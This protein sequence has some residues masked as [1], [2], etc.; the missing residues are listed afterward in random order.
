M[1][2]VAAVARIPG[3]PLV[4]EEIELD[5]PRDDEVLVEVAACGVCHTDAKA[6]HGY[7]EVRLP[8]VLGH[9]GAVTVLEVG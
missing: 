3:A 2:A 6:R 9:E 8:I 7:R 1:R 5:D 4:L